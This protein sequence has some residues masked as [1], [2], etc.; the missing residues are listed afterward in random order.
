MVA[1]TPLIS[2]VIPTTRP[3]YLKYSLRSVLTQTFEDFEVVLAFNPRNPNAAALDLP[4]DPRIKIVR[5]SHFLPM[6]DNWENGFAN[7]T[8]AWVTL[9]GD[10]DCY[11]PGALAT[12]AASLSKIGDSDMLIW[13]WGGFMAPDMPMPNAGH[14]SIP[15]FSGSITTDSLAN[16]G[17]LLYSFD[18]ERKALMKKWLPSIMRG[19][20]RRWHVEAARKRSGMFCYPLT[21]DYG[22]AGQIVAHGK[23]ID[24]LDFP[25]VI[26]NGTRDSMG[27]SALGLEETRSEQLYGVA[28]NPRFVH[29]P[30]QARLETNL[31]LIFETL[32][33][34]KQIY[35]E[36]LSFVDVD[37]ARFL[38]WHSAGL[39]EVARTGRDTSRAERELAQVVEALPAD[40]RT[41]VEELQAARSAKSA[42][43]IPRISPLTR[44]R[45][46]YRGLVVN[47][48]GCGEIDQFASFASEILKL[49]ARLPPKEHS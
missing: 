12:I 43:A 17:R 20:V 5:A 42:G 39:L 8:G 2:I 13:R 45:A 19:A 3:H 32:M 25:L 49:P 24:L 37:I 14:G 40:V 26:L 36:E 7:A 29:S 33:T 15:P 4:D 31:P 41:R 22:A 34:V 46:R 48:A 1:H 18:A 9:L 44:L 30:V 27:A 10:D 21:P 38:D 35:K 28:G 23:R 16:V 6:H 47:M 11:V